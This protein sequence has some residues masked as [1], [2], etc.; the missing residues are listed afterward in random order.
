MPI[1]TEVGY[2]HFF[3]RIDPAFCL[4]PKV[5]N[6]MVTKIKTVPNQS[7]GPKG[8]FNQTTATAA[9]ER[10]STEQSKL[11]VWA[12]IIVTEVRKM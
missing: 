9:A 6:T 12:P 1:A 11:A 7:I 4:V 5:N 3:Y 8:T 2:W 10:G